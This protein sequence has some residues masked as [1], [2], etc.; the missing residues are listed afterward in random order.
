MRQARYYLIFVLVSFCVSAQNRP[1]VD[2]FP[3]IGFFDFIVNYLS[4]PN[5]LST[6]AEIE[7]T[8]KRYGYY[9]DKL[10]ELGLTNFVSDG[11]EHISNLTVSSPFRIN[12]MGFS[13]KADPPHNF[14]PSIY[15]NAMGHDKEAYALEFGGT[16]VGNIDP[17]SANYG[18]VDPG[19]DNANYWSMTPA[20]LPEDIDST[21][22]DDD[23][24]IGDA[25]IYFRGVRT[26]NNDLGAIVWGKLPPVQFPFSNLNHLMKIRIRK[27]NTGGDNDEAIRII[28]SSTPINQANINKFYSNVYKNASI[29]DANLATLGLDQTVLGSEI[30]WVNDYGWFESDPFTLE[31]YKQLYFAILWSGNIDLNIDKIAIMTEKYDEVFENGSAATETFMNGIKANILAVYGSNPGST[32]QDFYFDEPYLLTA[33]Y[34]SKLQQK[35]REAYSGINTMQLN[36]AT[37][38]VPEYFHKFAHE[39]ARAELNQPVGNYVLFNMYP[40]DETDGSDQATV[41]NKLN[42]LIRCSSFGSSHA[43]HEYNYA[44]LRTALKAANQYDTDPTND[45]PL[46]MTLQVHAEHKVIGDQ[47]APSDRGRRA[48]SRD[49]IFAMGN[50]SL[51]YG[52]KGFMY[53]MVPTRCEIQ[54]TNEYWGTY[55]L[56]D[57][58]GNEY[59]FGTTGGWLQDAGHKQIP[60]SRF[61]AV[62][63]FITSTSLVDSVLLKLRWLDAKG[64]NRTESCSINFID[65]VKTLNPFVT[66]NSWDAVSYVETGFFEEINPS[67]DDVVPPNFVYVVNK[68]CNKQEIPIEEDIH[69]YSHRYV[70]LKFNLDSDYKNYTIHDLKTDSVYYIGFNGSLVLYLEAGHGTL[71]KIEPTIQSGGTLASDETVN[72]NINVKGNVK[73]AAGKTLTITNGADMKFLNSSKL[74]VSSANLY[75]FTTG[76]GSAKLD[77]VSRNWTAGNGIIASGANVSINN[78]IIKNA[79]TAIAAWNPASL[80]IS[81]STIE[82]CWFGVSVESRPVGSI[83]LDNVKVLGC[84]ERGVTLG[85]ANLEIKNSRISGSNYGIRVGT[86]NACAGD[87][88]ESNTYGYDTLSGNTIG[89]YSYDSKVDFGSYVEEQDFNSINNFFSGNDTNIVALNNSE[90]TA[91]H[92][93]W[94]NIVNLKLRW[95]QSSKIMT[96]PFFE[97]GMDNPEKENGSD[98]LAGNPKLSNGEGGT[99]REKIVLIQQLLKQKKLKQARN[100]CVD[101]IENNPDDELIPLALRLFR[102]TYTG[103]EITE[104]KGFVKN[105][106]NSRKGTLAKGLL[107]VDE[108]IYEENPLVFL[109]SVA[110]EYTKK[111]PAEQA[112][113]KKALYQLM[114]LSDRKGAKTSKVRL[115]ADFPES[116]YLT[117]LTLLLSDSLTV[118][119]NPVNPGLGKSN[120]ESVNTV[121]YEYNL[122]NNYPNPFNPETVIKFS[123]KEKSN[124]T[125]TVYNITGQKVTEL[126]TGEMEKGMYEKRFNGISHSSGVYIFRLEAQSLESSDRYTKTVKAMLLK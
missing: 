36:G 81:N 107:K 91:E 120:P 26:G 124:V 33:R 32:I 2:Y 18:F 10:T 86:G 105:G 47:Y 118:R 23:E 30:Q 100:I 70:S 76:T 44:G 108:A 114:V 90:V 7:D 38:G 14:N 95:D 78:A 49:E 98:L 42:E 53:Y 69:D 111:I 56:F 4:P 43:L 59:E 71:L 99:V 126:A 1:G 63:D 89:L 40:F 5:N 96:Y 22:F 48:P 17:V 93:F 19:E 11:Q 50:L 27:L 6:A 16:P 74:D 116:V 123:L 73:L 125:L 72:Y 87:Y 58:E 61:T 51:A 64:W 121:I 62:K 20:D 77:F 60:N 66:P 84:S 103:D 88:G 37:G 45:V 13:W 41:Q 55:G 104:Y 25:T 97:S 46:F 119:N 12:D 92:D 122:Y 82:N 85:T 109:D 115:E 52:V 68:R 112:L 79:S 94:D 117:D 9:F 113:Y 80:S 67:T 34:R 110:S 102:S 75:I 29:P 54:A 106:N 15:M 39:Y 57:E 65:S 28:V 31:K 24:E 8:T 35:I 101:I 3:Q 83:Y 21:G